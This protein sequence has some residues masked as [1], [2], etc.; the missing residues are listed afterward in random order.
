MPIDWNKIAKDAAKATDE[1]FA[2]Q[3]SGLT[4][5]NDAEIQ[6]LIFDTGISKEDLTAV[7]KE[8]KNASKGNKAKAT[9]ISNINNGVQVL[10]EIAKKFI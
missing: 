3:I 7:L 2:G 6:K 8:V 9:A 5:L 1:E 4:S 10:V